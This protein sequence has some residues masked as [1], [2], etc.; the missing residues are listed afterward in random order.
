VKRIL[1]AFVLLAVSSFLLS[2]LGA[3]Q[4][5]PGP[6]SAVQAPDIPAP[7]PVT[8]DA[9]TTA[10]LALDFIE[11]TCQ[12]RPGC[13]ASLP[14]VANLLAK[15]RA[16]NVLV[17]YSMGRNPAPFMAQV[18]P[19]GDEPTVGSSAN[20]F[21]ETNLNDILVGAGIDTVVLAGVAANGAVLYTSFGA[22]ERG[23][24]VVVAEDGI[25]AGPDFDVFLTRYQLLNQPGFANPQNMPLQP[26]AVTLSSTDLITFR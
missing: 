2:G 16:A 6:D 18:A 7:V 1:T 4:A 3:A 26:N 9:R 24:R 5:G 17:V 14:R 10:F 23:Y 21:Y 15:A 20:K 13:V 25:S 22:N 19:R 12:P 8:V 11:A